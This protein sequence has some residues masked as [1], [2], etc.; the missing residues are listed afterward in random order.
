M[1]LY[2]YHLS[3]DPSGLGM[4]EVTV[5]VS[6]LDLRRVRRAC[7]TGLLMALWL[8]E[9]NAIAAVI[10]LSAL[11]HH[12]AAGIVTIER[13]SNIMVIWLHASPTTNTEEHGRITHTS[14]DK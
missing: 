5:E 8:E 9:L 11:L 2:T 14:K 6:M 1:I 7:S 4:G 12:I 10:R 13:G 3:L